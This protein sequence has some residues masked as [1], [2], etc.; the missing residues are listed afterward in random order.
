MNQEPESI[1]PRT[2]RGRVVKRIWGALPSLFVIVFLVFIFGLFVGIKAE[3]ERLE[4]KKMATR[5]KERPPVNI[6]VQEIIPTPI[7]ERI[8][9]PGM[10]EAWVDLG[11]LAEVR[12]VVVEVLLEEGDSV[13]KGDVIALLD[14]RD[15]DY[16]LSEARAAYGLAISNN[17]RLKALYDRELIPKSDLDNA[18]ANVETLRAQMENARLQL[19]RCRIRSPISGVVNRLD[20]EE[21]LFLSVG[22][23]VAEILKIDSVKVSVG[24]PESDVDA[25]RQLNTFEITVDAL[26]GKTIRAEKHFLSVAPDSLA[27]LYRLELS[28]D[29]RSGE[30][31]PG[32]FARV[33]IVKR[34]VPDAISIPI[35]AV[36]SRNDAHFV[37]VDQGGAAHATEVE[38]GILEGWRIQVTRGLHAG[39]RVIVVGQ[40]NVDEGQGLNVVRTVRDP[41]ELLK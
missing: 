20:A 34:E 39:D 21:G 24:I 40:R 9:L 16:A 8:N 37:Y 33:E 26:S 19:D 30:L 14:T 38:L 25:V 1:Q 17:N 3:Q 4:A 32:M 29:N 22:D 35:Y 41:G 6:V 5:K 12:G 31:L 10:V 15:Y 2:T 23:P 13:T 7:R 28:L 18:E 11:L 36:I 27:Q